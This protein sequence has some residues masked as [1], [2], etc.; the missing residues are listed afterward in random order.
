MC[1]VK[2]HYS[3]KKLF[4][5]VFEKETSHITKVGIYLYPEQQLKNIY[6]LINE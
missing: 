6:K 3:Y 2:T 1:S 4:W 5:K